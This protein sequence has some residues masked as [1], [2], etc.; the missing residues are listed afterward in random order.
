MPAIYPAKETDPESEKINNE[1]NTIKADLIITSAILG[2]ALT[3]HYQGQP[4]QFD[5]EHPEE[6]KFNEWSEILSNK[7]A[8][9]NIELFHEILEKYKGPQSKIE[10]IEIL[11]PFMNM[12]AD[13]EK[14]NILKSSLNDKQKN[15]VE[16]LSKDEFRNKLKSQMGLY[17]EY[18][19]EIKDQQNFCHI[20]STISHIIDHHEP[21]ASDSI[22]DGQSP[23]GKEGELITGRKGSETSQAKFRP[24]PMSLSK[25]AMLENALGEKD[26]IY[27]GR[28]AYTG[29]IDDPSC[30]H[31]KVYPTERIVYPCENGPKL[32]T[33]PTSRTPQID[34]SDLEEPPQGLQLDSAGQQTFKGKPLNPTLEGGLWGVIAYPATLNNDNEKGMGPINLSIQ[35]LDDF[36]TQHLR[37]GYVHGMCSAIVQCKHLGP[38][39]TPY[40]MAT[41]TQTTKM[42][43]C[44]ACTTYMYANGYP[45]SS[46]HL[47]RGESWVPPKADYIRIEKDHKD[48][49]CEGYLYSGTC[50]SEWQ[51]EIASYIR[52]GIKCM[53]NSSVAEHI[54]KNYKGLLI[55]VIQ[56]IK[57]LTPSNGVDKDTENHKE[58]SELFLEALTMH[59]KDSDRIVAVF[60]PL[61][62][63]YVC[64]AEYMI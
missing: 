9:D 51:R 15:L 2:F 12:M 60:K 53:G 46:I 11:L 35:Q 27:R 43:S 10:D 57:T 28:G 7:E 59:K 63:K 58:I 39:A 61:Y 38:W 1:E 33:K 16:N 24:T 32:L 31:T 14:R 22:L 29:V 3:R 6:R 40:E 17:L 52:L 19:K 8:A 37:V 21:D 44:F 41:G 34:D 56:Q 5:Y 64:Q 36:G 50:L 26:T 42:A 30:D 54:D 62:E 23:Q 45:P 48:S 49:Q 13:S 18:L 55:E 25:A 4:C 20:I 47:G